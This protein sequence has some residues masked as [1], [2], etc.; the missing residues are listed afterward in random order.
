MRLETADAEPR[1][2]G[3]HPVD[4]ARAL[5]HQR[6]AF[7]SWSPVVFGF[8][9]RNSDHGAVA[10]LAAQPAQEDTQKHF[11]VDAVGLGPPLFPGDRDRGRMDHVRLDAAALKPAREPEAVAA[12]FVGD[13]DAGDW[14]PR[15]DRFTSPALKKAE[16]IFGVGVHLLLG[17][18]LDARDQ[19]GHGPALLTELDHYYQSSYARQRR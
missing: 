11:S 2:V 10:A 5:R 9:G 16:Q 6:L 8:D 18:A 3:L 17:M 1:H 15:L 13:G 14:T 7:T 12:G 4:D 19:T